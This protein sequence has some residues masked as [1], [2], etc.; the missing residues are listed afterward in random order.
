MSDCD[1]CG[2]CAE[3]YTP[4]DSDPTELQETRKMVADWIDVMLKTYHPPTGEDEPVV[5]LQ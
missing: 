4:A 3:L 1:D 2:H 5:F